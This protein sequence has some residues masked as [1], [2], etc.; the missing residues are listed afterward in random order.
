M[1][2]SAALLC[3]LAV[4]GVAQA[5]D[6]FG[7]GVGMD[8]SAGDYGSDITTEIFSVPVSAR[9]VTGDWTFKGNLP[10]MRVD[11]D[12]NVVPGLGTVNN[13]NPNGRGRGRGN[14]P[15]PEPEPIAPT[16]GVTSG[17]GDLRL[18][19]TYAVPSQ[20]NWGVDLTGTVKLATADEDK[21]LGTG[22]NDYG[23]VVDVFR[24]FDGTTAFGGVGYTVMGDS[25]YIDV[26]SVFGVNLGVS[27]KAGDNSYGAMYDWRQAASDDS[28]DRSEVTAFFTMPA[29]ES[30]K[31]QLYGSHGLSDGSP[32][33]AAGFHLNT[34]F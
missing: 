17:I 33:W 1:K 23:V 18:S 24:D 16:S 31:L 26:D 30:S 22:A 4:A 19:A 10:W 29:W 11:G 27:R 9:Y 21:G 2:R 13:T 28:D 7:L 8:Y 3:A 20:G 6:G 14:Q 5:D 12:A 15:D 25:D 34:S 32:E